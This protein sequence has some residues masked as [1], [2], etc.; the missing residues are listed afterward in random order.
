MIPAYPES[1]DIKVTLDGA[2]YP[3]V[4]I[5]FII[6]EQDGEYVSSEDDEANY[7]LFT[8]ASEWS[9]VFQDD[10]HI[11]VTPSEL[12]SDTLEHLKQVAYPT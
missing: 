4:D 3:L 2:S 7:G 8:E 9:I 12:D 11:E 10:T 6:W 1:T 5:D